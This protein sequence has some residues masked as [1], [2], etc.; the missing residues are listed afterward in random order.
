[1]CPETKTEKLTCLLWIFSYLS[2]FC[3]NL[4]LVE[5]AA[6]LKTPRNSIVVWFSD[7]RFSRAADLKTTRSSIVV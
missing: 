2:R 6:D 5:R 3:D 7:N 1:M 4:E